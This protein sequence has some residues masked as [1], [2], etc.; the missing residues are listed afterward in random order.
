MIM[1]PLGTVQSAMIGNSQFLEG[2]ST[3][4]RSALLESLEREQVR[5][6]LS[7]LSYNFV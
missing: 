2:G 3:T 6:Q 7:Q 4:S 1:L 5:S